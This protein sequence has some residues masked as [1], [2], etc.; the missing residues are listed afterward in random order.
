MHILIT[1]FLAGM[2]LMLCFTIIGLVCISVLGMFA[3]STRRIDK[4][5]AVELVIGFCWVVL[6]IALVVSLGEGSKHLFNWVTGFGFGIALIFLPILVYAADP[7]I[8]IDA[9][10]LKYKHNGE[11]TAEYIELLQLPRVN[12]SE[13]STLEALG[14]VGPLVFGYII[15]L[16]GLLF[17]FLGTG[18]PKPWG[19]FVFL[20][21]V[22]AICA[23]LQDSWLNNPFGWGKRVV[24]DM[25]IKQAIHN[26][27]ID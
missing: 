4:R 2:L 5:K 6:M 13:M 27:Q 19:S 1:L 17:G 12:N 22:V 9:V 24:T 23:T 3:G 8:V 7:I 14:G 21:L 18:L 15:G 11:L 10:S 20:N 16:G 26:R 25:E